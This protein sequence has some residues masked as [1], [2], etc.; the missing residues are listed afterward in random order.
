[1]IRPTPAAGSLRPV[2]DTE[3]V[4]ARIEAEVDR[5]ADTLLEASHDIHAH[6]E[7]L[8]EERYAHDLLTRV[9]EDEGL[10][11]ERGAYGLET[12]LRRPGR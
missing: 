7:L 6:P 10:E 3:E 5:L 4:K 9:L 12:G 11:V 1:M 2:A 8:F